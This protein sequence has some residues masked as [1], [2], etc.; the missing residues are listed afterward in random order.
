MSARAAFLLLMLCPAW[1]MASP[2]GVLT[3]PAVG[4]VLAQQRSSSTPQAERQQTSA[5][6]P[7][8]KA[9]QPRIAND[10]RASQPEVKSALCAADSLQDGEKVAVAEAQDSK[11]DNAE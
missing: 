4:Q 11:R 3:M 2:L 8:D 10:D 9:A 5:P 7:A 1:A 6:A